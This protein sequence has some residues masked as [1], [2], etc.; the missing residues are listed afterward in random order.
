MPVDLSLVVTTVGRVPELLRLARSV[1][2]SPVADRLE[3]IVVDQSPDRRGLRAIEEL[4]APLRLR[5][6]TS[7]RGASVGR[8][9][10]LALA[11]GRFVGFPNDNTSYPEAAL[12]ALLRRLAADPGLDGLSVLVTTADGRPAML[13]WPSAAGPVRRET[14]HRIGITPSF[15]L[16]RDLVARIG[17]FDERLGTGSPGPA[18]S[19]EDSDLVLRALADGARIEFDPAVVVHNDEPRDRL[20]RGFVT[21]MAGYGVGQGVLWRRHHLPPALLAGLMARKLVAAPVRAARGQSIQ[22]RSDLA[23][24]RGCLRGYAS[25]GAATAARAEPR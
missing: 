4:G 1:A 3:L 18:Q 24:A 7:A 8:N 14:V 23:W 19:G 25:A 9:A 13:R 22:A 2:A 16:R 6:A 12:P 21:K 15:F 20:D 11:V 17:G 10:G 5:T